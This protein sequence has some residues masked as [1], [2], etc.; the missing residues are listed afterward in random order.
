MSILVCGV[1]DF[2][3]RHAALV[4]DEPGSRLAGVV[5]LDGARA[6]TV[7]GGRVPAFTDLAAGLAATTPDAVIVAT[8]EHA[9]VG[10]VE[11]SLAAGAHVLVEKP[12]ALSAAAIDGLI[13][14]AAAAQRHVLPAHVSRFLPEVA[15]LL[16]EACTPRHV[17]ASRVVPGARRGPHGRIHPAWMAMIHDLDLIAALLPSHCVVRV[18]AAERRTPGAGA[19]PDIC[20]ALLDVQAGPVVSVDNVWLLPHERQYIDARVRLTCDAHTVSLA[21]PGDAAVRITA[22]GEHRPDHAIDGRLAGQ[23]VGALGVQLRHLLDVVEGRTAPVVSL[24]DA[25]RAALLAEAVVA[26]AAD[27]HPVEVEVR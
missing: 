23:P 22:A 19:H 13:G 5:D 12:V 4:D 16:A 18:H 3:A 14:S 17:H 25:R 8:P 15:A 24:V 11:T 9:H 21:T 7:A 27:G 1:G 10:D 26:A 2:G 6:E 20:S